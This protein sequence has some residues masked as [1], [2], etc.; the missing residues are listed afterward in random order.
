MIMACFNSAQRMLQ[1]RLAD[2][3][4]R[5]YQDSFSF[6]GD[7]IGGDFSA[8]AIQRNQSKNLYYGLTGKH[9]IE[10]PVKAPGIKQ[11]GLS[12][13]GQ[14]PEPVPSAEGDSNVRDAT[15]ASTSMVGRILEPFRSLTNL[16]GAQNPTPASE[17]KTL[18]PAQKRALRL[19]MARPDIAH[20]VGDSVIRPQA[21]KIGGYRDEKEMIND[22]EMRLK[23]S[24]K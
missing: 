19:K 18:T 7:L 4:E 17:N 13:S 8:Y 5:E 12:A 11:D 1:A 9:V 16:W 24:K 2:Y 22:L 23:A 10:S 6:L 14:P 3:A 15:A 21:L 20:L